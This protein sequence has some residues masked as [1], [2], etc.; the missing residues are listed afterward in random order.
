MKN[1]LFNWKLLGGVLL[2]LSLGSYYLTRT[3]SKPDVSV[4]SWFDQQLLEAEATFEQLEAWDIRTIYQFI[5]YAPDERQVQDFLQLAE[6]YEKDVYFLVGEPEWALDPKAT[7]LLAFIQSL[8]A[9][10]QD[11]GPLKGLVIDV[12]PQ[13]L[14]EF[15]EDPKRVLAHYISG[16]TAAYQAAQA[17]GLTVILCLPNSYDEL[18]YDAEL[19]LLI[20]EAADQVA[21][22][23]YHRG[24]EIERLAGEAA[25][26]LNYHKPL[27]NIY[28]LQ[29]AGQFDLTPANTY[30]GLN[31]ADIFDNFEQLRQAYPQQELS[32]SL[33]EFRSLL[34]LERGE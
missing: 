27:I 34:E 31:A 11:E 3:Q 29:A 15:Q 23:N 17:A 4:F 18:G 2:L 7:D 6:Q 21:I 14:P 28:E 12:E 16:M 26:A 10:Q 25:L 24:R 9:Y 22:M 30:H 33:H 20:S 32:L 1:K 5:S 13:S 8:E 19:E